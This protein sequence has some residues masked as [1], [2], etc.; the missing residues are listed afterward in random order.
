MLF[1]YL[2]QVFIQYFLV[3][4]YVEHLAVNLVLEVSE[5]LLLAIYVPLQALEFNVEVEVFVLTL[6]E[7][8]LRLI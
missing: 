4:P 5:L 2:L 3:L 7:F 1:G 8:D 6:Y